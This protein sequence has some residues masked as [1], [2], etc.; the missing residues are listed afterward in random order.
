MSALRRSRTSTKDQDLGLFG[1]LI[2]WSK[3][4]FRASKESACNPE[5]FSSAGGIDV[6]AIIGNYERI[7]GT[8]KEVDV[9]TSNESLQS[10]NLWL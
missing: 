1:V 4:P 5:K 2:V 3:F 7:L 9:V 6:I 10:Q 8:N